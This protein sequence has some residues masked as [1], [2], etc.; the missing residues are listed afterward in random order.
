MLHF[1]LAFFGFL[2]LK[3]KRSVWVIFNNFEW[4]PCDKWTLSRVWRLNTNGNESWVFFFCCVYYCEHF[5][6]HLELK[7]NGLCNSRWRFHRDIAKMGKKSF[8]RTCISF[9]YLF[10]FSWRILFA[11]LR[12]TVVKNDEKKVYCTTAI[13]TMDYGLVWM[14]NQFSLYFIADL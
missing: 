13:N 10:F 1:I 5:L 12:F 8:S 14:T 7:R 6:I 3:I 11:H 9:F 2:D 4:A